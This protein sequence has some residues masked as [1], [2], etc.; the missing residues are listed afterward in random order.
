[1]AASTNSL[2]R[3]TDR[4]G[5]HQPRQSQADSARFDVRDRAPQPFGVWLT[6]TEACDYLRYTG[7][8]RLRSLYKFIARN[9]VKTSRRSARRL[10]IARRDLDQLVE[11][12][13]K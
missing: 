1:M 11:R 5:Q 4:V 2:R 8:H 12:G 3:R 9:Q 13:G 7:K 6:T 10:L